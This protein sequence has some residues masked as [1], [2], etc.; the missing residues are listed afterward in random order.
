MKKE[1]I[2]TPVRANSFS[3]EDTNKTVMCCNAN[4]C[5]TGN[6]K[7]IAP[8]V[9]SDGTFTLET[10]INICDKCYGVLKEKFGKEK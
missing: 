5:E 6:N 4:C 3:I 9:I 1:I 7:L 2:V 8:A 10:R